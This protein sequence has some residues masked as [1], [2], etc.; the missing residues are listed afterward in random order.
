MKIVTRTN[1]FRVWLGGLVVAAGAVAATAAPAV[2]ADL[3]TD[4]PKLTA[5][6]FDFGY[7]WNTWDAPIKG[8][9]LFWDVTNGLVTP[10]LEGYL[11]LK[12]AAGDCARMHIIH[13]DDDHDVVGNSYSDIECTSSNS[14]VQF[15]VNEDGFSSPYISH[16]HVHL[17]VDYNNNGS[18]DNVVTKTYNLGD[19]D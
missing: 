16:V 7:V 3:D 10:D 12:N 6:S 15:F 13:Y 1:L 4:H 9:D 17:D 18:W 5:D 8:G 14:K 19:P 11:Y 2:A